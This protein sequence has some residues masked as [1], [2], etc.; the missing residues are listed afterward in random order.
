MNEVQE[1]KRNDVEQRYYDDEISLIDLWL[2]L[3]RRKWIVFG[4]TILCVAA[5]FLYASMQPVQYEYSSGIE[6]ARIF[7]RSDGGDKLV[8]LSSR[9]GSVALLEDVII[10]SQR[11]VLFD[12]ETS[13]PRVSVSVRGDSHHL[14][15]SS[16][17]ERERADRVKKLHEAV[18]MALAENHASILENNIALRVNP[19][20]TRAEMLQRLVEEHEGQLSH[21][22]SRN[23]EGNDILGLIDVQQMADIRRELAEVRVD[24]ADAMNVVEAFEEASHGTRIRFLGVESYSP[25]GTGKTLIVALSLVLGVMLGVFG[26]FFSEFLAAVRKQGRESSQ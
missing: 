16:I 7:E 19:L 5:G 14:M 23:H 12:E 9:D 18:V 15:I 21:L 6:L 13:V 8:L 1:Y 2:V 4:V 10:P 26:A 17:V 11:K 24:L 25:V 22:A 3:A 20:K